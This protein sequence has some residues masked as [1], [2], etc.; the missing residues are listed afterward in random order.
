M[1]DDSQSTDGLARRDMLALIAA[2]GVGGATIAPAAFA[3]PTPGVPV[4]PTAQAV[5][6]FA[7]LAGDTSGKV[8]L[9]YMAG[10]VWG[11]RPL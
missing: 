2:A 5:E 1:N 3:A 8:T 11:F 10:A 9:S 4:K 7:K 6:L